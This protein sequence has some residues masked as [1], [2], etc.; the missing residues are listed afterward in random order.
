M[1]TSSILGIFFL[2]ELAIVTTGLAAYLFLQ[3]KR[4]KLKVK[5][6]SS[7]NDK[8]A[9]KTPSLH[10]LFDMQITRT[11][12][13]ITEQLSAESEEEAKKQSSLLSQR[14]EFLKIEKEVLEE[15]VTDQ[16][17]WKKLCDRIATVVTNYPSE[18]PAEGENPEII[19]DSVYKRRIAN[20]Q[21]QL[22]DLHSEFENYRKYSNKLASGLSNYDKDAEQD[23]AL[24]ELMA[25]FKEHDER[26]H[27]H[28][29][30]LQK[31]NEKLQGNLS[32]AEREEYIREYQAKKTARNGN[33]ELG[34]KTASEEEIQRLRDIIGRQYDSIDG[35][36]TAILDTQSGEIDPEKVTKKLQDVERAQQE[37]QTCI[38]V[39][40]MENDRLTNELEVARSETKVIE[41]EGAAPEELYELRLQ[42]KAMSD[43]INTLNTQISDKDTK[44]KELE[45]EYEN[46]QKEFM[47]MYAEQGS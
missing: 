21:E 32:T 36:R 37:L 2:L 16:S 9:E 23:N 31:E 10:D 18:T 33:L 45:A 38:E 19:D 13:K 25:D 17:Y 39:L 5:T 44:I 8:D 46:L 7:N 3:L 40:E 43:Q 35:L 27:A 20:Y 26:L 42:S 24:N 34:S 14:I 4:I 28:L 12:K 1:T 22:K 47:Q 41:V 30:Q 29:N 15:H 6:Q 11:R